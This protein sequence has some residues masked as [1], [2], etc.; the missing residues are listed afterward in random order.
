MREAEQQHRLTRQVVESLL[1]VFQN[2]AQ[3]NLIR[4]HGI[5]CTEQAS[6]DCSQTGDPLDLNYLGSLVCDIGNNTLKPVPGVIKLLGNFFLS[7]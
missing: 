6:T 5:L 4:S 1:Q 7:I 2:K 3:K